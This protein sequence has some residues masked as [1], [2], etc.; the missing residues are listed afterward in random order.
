MSVVN[1][2]L[3][4]LIKELRM[5]K[6]SFSIRINVAPA[7]INNI[8][9]GRRSRPSFDVIDKIKTQFPNVNM[10]W[11]IA[12]NGDMFLNDE[13]AQLSRNALELKSKQYDEFLAEYHR[14]VNENYRLTEENKI[15]KERAEMAVNQSSV[16]VQALKEASAA[17][18]KSIAALEKIVASLEAEQKTK[19]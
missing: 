5:N 10:E 2:R 7:V 1:D 16:V 15:A 8:I 6:N 3:L 17:K 18:E 9:G 11:F 12:G 13:K 19:K 14:M 4:E